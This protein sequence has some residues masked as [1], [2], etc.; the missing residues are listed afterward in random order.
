MSRARRGRSTGAFRRERP[1]RRDHGP[2]RAHR[3][4]TRSRRALVGP[5]FGERG[6]E[7]KILAAK[8]A[9]EN[10]VP[11]LGI[12]LGMQ[13][14]IIEFARDVCGIADAHSTEFDHDTKNPVIGLVTEWRDA[15]G[16][17]QKRDTTSDKGGTMRVGAQKATLKAGSLAAEVYGTTE[18]N[19]RHRHRYEV[20]SNYVAQFEA[21][22]L[23]VSG[24]SAVQD[25]VEVM[26]Y[27]A[28]TH[29]WF[30][31]V[32]YHPEFNSTP[33]AGHPLFKAFVGAAMAYRD[34]RVGG[35]A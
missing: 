18:I 9:R 4:R 3:V 6:I 15:A 26:E 28:A 20:N 10:K 2:G 8:Y 21:K 24:R 34:G 5:G 31:G 13:I 14:A 32:Q 16:A 35:A 27:P 22:G 1:A 19:E 11:Y 33:R 23:V 25:L 12:C 29:P 30:I 17:V 7:G